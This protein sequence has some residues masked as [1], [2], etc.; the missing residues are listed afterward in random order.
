MAD[1]I[2]PN[3]AICPDCEA[4][5][6]SKT[7]H[8]QCEGVTD[9]E[10]KLMDAICTR[11]RLYCVDCGC[12]ITEPDHSSIHPDHSLVLEYWDSPASGLVN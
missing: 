8:W 11:K 7:H 5:F 10:C 3:T 4:P 2:L 9:E 1:S 12:I 6:N